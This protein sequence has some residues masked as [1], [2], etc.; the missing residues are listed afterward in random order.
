[1]QAAQK[2]ERKLFLSRTALLEGVA[3]RTITE[4]D[5]QNGLYFL[6]TNK[7]WLSISNPH[8]FGGSRSMQQAYTKVVPFLKKAREEGR[9]FLHQDL[10]DPWG[11]L[12]VLLRNNGYRKLHFFSDEH[13]PF[14][15]TIA[16]V[17]VV[18][19]NGKYLTPVNISDRRRYSY[20]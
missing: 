7:Q 14:E 11:C 15:E 8:A 6:N 12:E 17:K 18:E 3:D 16:A 5:L 20:R 19:R 1:M 9:A 13:A 2:K 4:E 10:A